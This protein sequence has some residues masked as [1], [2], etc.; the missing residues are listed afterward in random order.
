LE[1]V[2]ERERVGEIADVE[3]EREVLPGFDGRGSLL[4]AL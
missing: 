1:P 2:R 4:P 3:R